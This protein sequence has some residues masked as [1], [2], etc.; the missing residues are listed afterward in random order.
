MGKAKLD[1]SAIASTAA[2]D[3]AKAGGSTSPTPATLGAI[4]TTSPIPAAK[5]S[6]AADSKSSTLEQKDETCKP[7]VEK[8]ETCK[9]FARNGK[10]KFGDN[11]EFSHDLTNE[12]NIVC[13][14]FANGQVCKFGDQCRFSHELQSG[15]S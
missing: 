12:K 5:P 15:S 4:T 9:F 11:C 3:A 13:T 6:T 1:T 14:Y 7:V 2:S 10:C 8:K